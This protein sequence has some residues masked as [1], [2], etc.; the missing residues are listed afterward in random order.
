MN[1]DMLL[2][3][4]SVVFQPYHFLLAI[5]AVLVG[6][7]VGALPGMTA[8][9]TI[10]L[11]VPLT[12]GIDPTPSFVLLLGIY[13]GAIYGGSIS[14]VTICIPGTAAAAATIFDG[15]PMAMRGEAGKALG[16]AV[17]ASFFGGLVSAIIMTFLSPQLAKV[18]L[19]F[20]PPE[21]FGIAMFAISVLVFI[22]G[23]SLLK[24]LISG[25][26]GL[27]LATIG[28]D[29]NSGMERFTFGFSEMMQGIGIIPGCIGFFAFSQIFLEIDKPFMHAVRSTSAKIGTFL[30][31]WKELKRVFPTMVKS[32]LIGT[33]IGIIPGIGCETGC[34]VAYGEAKRASKNPERF[35]TGILEG[36]AAPEAGNN[37]TTGGAMI[38]MLSL[39]VPGDAITAVM[40][41]AFTLH[42]LTPGPLLFRDHLDLVYNIFAAMI[43]ANILMG[44]LG[45]TLARYYARIVN[46]P[47]AFLFPMVSVLCII[48]TFAVN[49][50]MFDVYVAVAL[51]FI[52]YCMRKY[53]YPV[54]PALI[55]IILGP[56]AEANYC[57]ALM[58]SHGS[59][60]IFFKSWIF[61]VF[62]LMSIVS[63][64]FAFIQRK[65]LARMM[66]AGEE[67]SDE[68]AAIITN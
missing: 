4:F 23:K 55:A 61:D 56:L 29:P 5:F 48:G 8:A 33:F 38:P 64:T 36:I 52:G 62:L 25:M 21:Y 18:A 20:G 2:Q 49:L 41:G 37:A 10:A 66:G 15:Y 60:L 13:N 46:I 35:G 45:W 39:G 59:Y 51:G 24:G 65:Q 67:G 17:I 9:M 63:F 58:L 16:M 28:M 30:L 34:F 50:S 14:A 3:G 42:G 27:V 7:L 6:I 68:P 53:E 22:S 32:T 19:R 57:R 54:A 40:L 12:Y 1:F 44:V 26:F 47:K 31:S 11:L 43:M